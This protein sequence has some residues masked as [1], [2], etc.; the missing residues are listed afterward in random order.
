VREFTDGFDPMFQTLR[1]VSDHIADID[2]GLVHLLADRSQAVRNATIFKA[3]PA[4]V[5]APGQQRETLDRVRAVAE[6]YVQENGEPIEGFV[7]LVALVFGALVRGSVNCQ[8]L[9]FT[10]TRPIGQPGESMAGGSSPL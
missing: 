2:R 5:S 4:E 8:Q 10:Q 1:E 3:N 9:A 6:E 7:D